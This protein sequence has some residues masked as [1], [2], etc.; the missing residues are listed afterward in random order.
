MC[1]CLR[2]HADTYFYPA[3]SRHMPAVRSTEKP[4]PT[5]TT[6]CLA[7]PPSQ[8]TPRHDDAGTLGEAHVLSIDDAARLASFPSGY[9]DGVSSRRV[10][11][12]LIGNC[13]PPATMQV[14]AA[15]CMHLVSSPAVD[16]C[17]VTP[18]PAPTARPCGMLPRMQRLVQAGLLDHG[19]VL[20]G[21]VLRYTCGDRKGDAVLEAVLTWR[22]PSKWVVQLTMRRVVSERHAPRDDLLLMAPGVEQPFRS[23]K[24][25]L[26]AVAGAHV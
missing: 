22:P 23:C 8:Y 9:F 12:R 18:Q 14:V 10:A 2:T 11:G 6:G 7:L 3:R 26:R 20:D 13:V 4:A 5:L 21:G 15:W 19:G 1:D 24:Q 17:S 25:A 16:G